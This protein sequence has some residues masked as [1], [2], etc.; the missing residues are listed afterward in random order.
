MLHTFYIGSIK[1]VSMESHFFSFSLADIRHETPMQ[2]TLNQK[3]SAMRIWISATISY[4][5]SLSIFKSFSTLASPLH[6]AHPNSLLTFNNPVGSSSSHSLLI[7]LFI[8]ISKMISIS[9]LQ[10]TFY[11]LKF[12][13]QIN[14]YCPSICIPFREG[15]TYAY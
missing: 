11:Q 6:L 12:I 15:A 14:V 9:F 5:S 8:K 3:P 4:T 10:F 2:K 7:F 13:F 1:I